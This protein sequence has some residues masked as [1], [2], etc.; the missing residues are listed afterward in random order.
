MVS[1]KY[2]SVFVS[3]GAPPCPGNAGRVG[4][5]DPQ[6]QAGFLLN[7]RV[8]I[9]VNSSQNSVVEGGGRAVRAFRG[10]VGVLVALATQDLPEGGAH[11]FVA[12]GVDDGV[13]SRVELGQE[14]EELLIGQDIAL[15]ATHIEQ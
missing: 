1:V 9:A 12:V 15:R 2:R 3:S 14:E 10:A 13:H 11:L 6:R 4:F 8:V 5:T 7:H